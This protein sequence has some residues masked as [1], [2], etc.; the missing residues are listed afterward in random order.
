M[1]DTISMLESEV[2]SVERIIEESQT[3]FDQAK[4]TVTRLKVVRDALEAQ[5]TSLKG[6]QLELDLDFSEDE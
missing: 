3:Q 6:H 2:A 4:D 1:E 5:I